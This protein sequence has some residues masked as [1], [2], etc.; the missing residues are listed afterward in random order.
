MVAQKALLDLIN[1]LLA[2]NHCPGIPKTIHQLHKIVGLENVSISSKSFCEQ[3]STP[4]CPEQ[5]CT[6]DRC[7]KKNLVALRS[8]LFSFVDFSAQL[9]SL[10]SN[11]FSA[12][13]DFLCNTRDFTDIIDGH[14]YRQIQ[15]PNRL[16]LLVYTDGVQVAESSL[17]NCWP[18]VLSV[19]ELP[20]RL[21]NSIQNKIVC[22]IWFGKKKPTSDVLFE[23]TTSLI[24]TINESGIDVVF[25]SIRF[26]LTIGL[27]GLV[28]DTPAKSL[29]MM[30]KNFNG[31]HGCP[32]CLNAGINNTI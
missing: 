24:D 23:S 13:N 5:K 1:I 31:E 11:N 20:C 19:V 26:K 18:V 16:N 22:G 30:V 17:L 12:I 4:L 10:V 29:C 28:V 14:H 32:Y 27:Y 15:Q 7:D 6:N 2:A 25:R 21:R 9:R 3:C 8:D